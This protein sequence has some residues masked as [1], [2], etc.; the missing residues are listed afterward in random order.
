MD[1]W[2][3]VPFHSLPHPAQPGT[4]TPTRH[5]PTAATTYKP[6]V[7]GPFQADVVDTFLHTP[8]PL[9]TDFTCQQLLPLSGCSGPHFFTFTVPGVT[10]SPTGRLLACYHTTPT[11]ASERASDTYRDTYTGVVRGPART[12]LLLDIQAEDL[13]HSLRHPP[14]PDVVWRRWPTATNPLGDR[15]ETGVLPGLEPGRRFWRANSAAT[16]RWRTNVYFP[17]M[18]GGPPADTPGY[19]PAC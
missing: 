5:S 4:P 13:D 12:G 2:M 9:V 8:P 17:F 1:I 15:R 18:F 11:S 16:Q 10:V 6:L 7:V 14:R 3:T 19:N